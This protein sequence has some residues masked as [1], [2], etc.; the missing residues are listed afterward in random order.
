MQ[1]YHPSFLIA[2]CFGLGK[3]PFMPGTIGS[4]VTFPILYYAMSFYS[5]IRIRFFPETEPFFL[6]IAIL[7]LCTLFFIFIGVIC[8][9]RYSSATSNPDPKE[10]IIDETAGQ[11]L[12]ISL[13]VPLS[14]VL[15]QH[16]QF[17]IDMSI[18]LPCISSFVLFRIFDIFKPWPI[19][20]IDSK[21]KGGIGIMLD[22]L[23]AALFAVVVHYAVLYQLI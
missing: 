15:L 12:V 3:I 1:Y 20:W 7:L 8:A 13:V 17:T 9:H 11:S 23:L 5:Q 2:T 22:D 19:S 4:L 16:A 10:V 14:V 6:M 21:V 18:L